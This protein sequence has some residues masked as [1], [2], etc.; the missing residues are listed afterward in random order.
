MY[1]LSDNQNVL[2]ICGY[3]NIFVYDEIILTLSKFTS[4]LDVLFL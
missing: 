3:K 4:K 1:I 2:Y